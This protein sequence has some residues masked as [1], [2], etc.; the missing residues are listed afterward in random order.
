MGNEKPIKTPIKTISKEDLNERIIAYV[1]S[2]GGSPSYT[3]SHVLE[4]L[5]QKELEGRKFVGY[6]EDWKHAM[7]YRIDEYKHNSGHPMIRI[8]DLTL[9]PTERHPAFKEDKRLNLELHLQDIEV[10]GF[11]LK[12][13]ANALELSTENFHWYI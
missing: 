9:G 2:K 7:I 4:C 12:E 8:S 3:L 1:E 13:V 6:D 10:T 5:G 11:N